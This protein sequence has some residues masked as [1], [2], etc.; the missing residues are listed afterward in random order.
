MIRLLR[1]MSL[2][3]S[4]SAL[5]CS[6]AQISERDLDDSQ[7]QLETAELNF[8]DKDYG[9]CV[10]LIDAITENGVL[11]PDALQKAILMR[12]DCFLMLGKIELAEQDVASVA[13]SGEQTEKVL[14]LTY[15]IAKYRNDTVRA[16]ETYQDLLQINP[17]T[18][19][20]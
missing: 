20:R 13:P 15:K 8:K 6:D 2:V 5:G 9:K 18:G 12:A 4:L 14:E 19:V 7:K 3:A 10:E 17:A 1:L 16:N 11:L